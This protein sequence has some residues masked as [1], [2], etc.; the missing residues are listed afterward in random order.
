MWW[1]HTVHKVGDEPVETISLGTRRACAYQYLADVSG[2]LHI[3]TDF[4]PSWIWLGQS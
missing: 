1:L 3:H 2:L 4:H